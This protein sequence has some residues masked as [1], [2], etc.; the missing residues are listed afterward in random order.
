[1]RLFE[2]ILVSESKVQR[3]QTT[4]VLMVT[5]KKA[6]EDRLLL[7]E[8]N[9]TEMKKVQQKE[10]IEKVKEENID[11]LMQKKKKLSIIEEKIKQDAELDDIPD[12]E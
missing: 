2:E 6:K 12:L 8:R 5:M 4:G 7:A 10:A 9:T 11:Q 1:M 3:S